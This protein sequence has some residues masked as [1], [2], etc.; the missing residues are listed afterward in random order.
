MV[1]PSGC[2][3][4]GTS[5]LEGS[6]ASSGRPCV[7]VREQGDS[8]DPGR[9]ARGAR[10]DEMDDVLPELFAIGV[11]I[12]SS[13]PARRRPSGVWSVS[14]S[15]TSRPQNRPS[16]W[17]LAANDLAIQIHGGYG[18]TR[19]YDVEQHYRDNRLNP[20]HEGAQQLRG[21]AEGVLLEHLVLDCRLVDALERGSLGRPSG[22]TPS[23][24]SWASSG[25]TFMKPG[26]KARTSSG[27]S[28][29]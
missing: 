22:H 19:E 23:W 15:S 28:S 17:C 12:S 18:Y 2:R 11:R 27:F 20:V 1:P 14:F 9:G 25:S 10:Q 6:F 13:S 3:S 16:Q 26:R 24:T 21:V 8:L 4:R 5:G 7:R 29:A